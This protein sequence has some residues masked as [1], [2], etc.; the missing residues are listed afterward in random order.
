MKLS[1]LHRNILRHITTNYNKV[2]KH[3]QIIRSLE[4]MYFS[5]FAKELASAHHPRYIKS[6]DA[7]SAA[8]YDLVMGLAHIGFSR[9][10]VSGHN[11]R[12]NN[13]T[14]TKT[15]QHIVLVMTVD[16]VY[17]KAICKLTANGIDITNRISNFDLIKHFPS[18]VLTAY[19]EARNEKNPV[20]RVIVD[21]REF[22]VQEKVF[23]KAHITF[24]IECANPKDVI[25]L[26]SAGYLH[27]SA[28][29]KY[30]FIRILSTEEMN[31][32]NLIENI[33]KEVFFNQN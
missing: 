14:L 29:Y 6:L 11:K 13:L 22:W 15:M 4:S 27:L 26:S 21:S 28:Q 16:D 7:R 31:H 20:S 23:P 18:V 17:G 5:D 10:D 30:N 9:V 8:E 3:N 1:F 12:G 32:P 24:I 19:V 2:V 33:I 25:N